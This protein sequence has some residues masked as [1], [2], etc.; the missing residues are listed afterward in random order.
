MTATDEEGSPVGRYGKLLAAAGGLPQG[1]D[2]VWSAHRIVWKEADTWFVRLTAW[3][4]PRLRKNGRQRLRPGNFRDL[5]WDDSE[6][7]RVLQ[8]SVFADVDSIAESLADAFDRSTFRAYHGCRTED[9]GSYFR[10]GLL[11]HDRTVLTER[12]RAFVES[13]PELAWLRDRLND[14]IARN[15]N[16]I[17]DG[18]LYVVAG[19]EAMIGHFGHYLIY[20][21]EWIS[22]VLGAY[23][24]RVL[25]NRGTPTIIEVDLPMKCMSHSMRTEFARVMLREWTRLICNEPDW[26]APIEFGIT[27]QFDL[28]PEFVVGHYHP[29]EIIDPLN[30]YEPYRP[31]ST[32]CAYCEPQDSAAVPITED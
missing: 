22:A 21:S 26:I 17:D 30:G 8:G 27:L 23:G 31:S 28:P 9:A 12:M 20:G 4:A 11:R 7:Q 5:C 6:W 15:T 18:R 1:D 16:T 13:E 2:Q 3:L 32:I 19:D 29:Q 14:Y 10:G 24:R 25:L